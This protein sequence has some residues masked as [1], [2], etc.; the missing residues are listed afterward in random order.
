MADAER[1]LGDANRSAG[2]TGRLLEDTRARQVDAE[3]Q[4]ALAGRQLVAARD[5]QGPKGRFTYASPSFC[6]L[7]GKTPDQILGKTDFDLF[8][9]PLATKYRQDDRQVLE[10]RAK[11][12]DTEIHQRPDGDRMHVQV[13]KV[14]LFD[15]QGQLAGVQGVFWDVTDQKRAEV[16]LRESEARKRA[17]LEAAIDCIVF[18]DESGRIVEF[19]RA[20]EATLGY[21][22]REVVGHEMAEIFIP[23]HLRERHRANLL[24]YSGARELGSMLGRNLETEMVRKNGEVFVAEMVTQPIPLEGATA[25]AVFIRD[26]TQRKQAEEALRHAK[27]AAEA[28]SQSKGLFLAN[29]SHEIR[30]PMNAILGMTEYLLSTPLA[31]EQR[32]HLEVVLESGNSL[33]GLLNDIL[34]LS[35]IEAGRLDLESAPFELRP[36]LRDS[37]KS[38]AFRAARSSSNWPGTSRPTPPNTCSA[39]RIASARS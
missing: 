36:W 3:A 33:M 8:P 38:L 9:K 35:K 24:R 34:D 28:A 25:F 10:Q 30:T 39:I 11:F 7:V 27:E 23:E 15:G 6:R 13:L 32:E 18:T 31:A 5:P 4:Y 14:P 16:E 22:R 21:T 12:E 2:E 20:A 1:A 26:I 37:L 19:N 29:M 17:I